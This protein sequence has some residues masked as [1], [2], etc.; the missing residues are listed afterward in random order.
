MCIYDHSSRLLI[1][2]AVHAPNR[3][4]SEQDYD[5]DDVQRT[6]APYP[7][8]PQAAVRTL[9]SVWY[10]EQGVD[11]GP[12]PGPA[13]ERRCFAI[14]PSHRLTQPG[15]PC[16]SSKN[17]YILL[18]LVRT[19]TVG[20]L[21]DVRRLVVAM[22]RARLGLYV[23]A[24]KELFQN[25]YELMST[26]N[27][28]LLKPT[29]LQLVLVSA[30]SLSLARS[31]LPPARLLMLPCSLSSHRPSQGERFGSTSRKTDEESKPFTVDDVTHAGVL[32]QQLLQAGEGQQ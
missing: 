3:L 15:L 26:F 16:L 24:R 2:S 31:S 7:R 12:I 5:L 25:C 10:A 21:R 8:C 27:Q 6:K 14:T 28:L 11:G 17:D 13:G 32:V 1:A 23:F 29:Q 18:S 22:S 20:H 9:P 4:P 19:R 30:C